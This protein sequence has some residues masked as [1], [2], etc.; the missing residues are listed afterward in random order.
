MNNKKIKTF[1]KSLKYETLKVI[2]LV[3]GDVGKTSIISK[4]T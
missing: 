4:F 2:F 3:E 1:I